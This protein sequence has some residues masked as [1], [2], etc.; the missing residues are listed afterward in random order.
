MCKF[1][2]C[3]V[4]R[5]GRVWHDGNSSSHEKAIKMSGLKDDKLEDRDFVRIEINPEKFTMKMK[6]W[7]F[8]IDE[9]GTLPEWFTR[10][11]KHFRKMCYAELFKYLKVCNIGKVVAF[12]E[13]L[14]EIKWFKPD[15]KPRKEWMMFKTWDAACD[16]AC[17]AARDASRS[18]ARSEAWYAAWDAARDAARD[19]SRSEARDASRSAARSEAWYAAWD[20][21]RDAARSAAWYAASNAAINAARDAARNAAWYAAEDAALMVRLLVVSDLKHKGKKKHEAHA[22]ARMEVWKKGYWLHCDVNGKLYVYV[23]EGG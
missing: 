1:W 9:E 5:K 22:K 19:A 12:I 10:E 6:D 17:D 16:A 8:K 2:S 11:R 20:A 4:D 14:K 18:A 23:N 3:I 21:A 15:G 13:S 7:K